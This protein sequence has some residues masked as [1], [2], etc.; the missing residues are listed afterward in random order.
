MGTYKNDYM[1]QEDELLREIHNI[2][3]SLH[4]KW[5]KKSIAERNSA[6]NTLFTERKKEWETKQKQLTGSKT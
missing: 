6:I 1:K 4:E 2:R 3:H 5:G